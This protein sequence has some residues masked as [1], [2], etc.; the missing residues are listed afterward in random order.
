MK[1]ILSMLTISALFFSVNANGL[2]VKPSIGIGHQNMQLVATRTPIAVDADI[3]LILPN[4]NITLSAFAFSVLGEDQDEIDYRLGYHW[5]EHSIFVGV[6][7]FGDIGDFKQR[8]D[9]IGYSFSDDEFGFGGVYGKP[10]KGDEGY[11][12]YSELGVFKNTYAGVNIGKEMFTK[13]GYQ[14]LY[15]RH[16]STIGYN[17]EILNKLAYQN[18]GTNDGW[19]ATFNLVYHLK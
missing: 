11:F 10:K 5:R 3:V 17:I 9:V 2:V 18:N 19:N 12:I 4:N 1:K 7:D 13:E 15:F 14:T 8:A 6:N 16:G